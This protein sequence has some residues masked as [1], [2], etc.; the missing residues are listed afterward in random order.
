MTGRIRRLYRRRGSQWTVTALLWATV[1]ASYMMMHPKSPVALEI[2]GYRWTG[3]P[4]VLAVSFAVY[5]VYCAVVSSTLVCARS[6][7]ARYQW[8]GWRL[9]RRWPVKDDRVVVADGAAGTVLKVGRHR[10][11]AAPMAKV[12]LDDGC[13]GWVFVAELGRAS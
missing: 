9:H 3:R 5:G 7:N 6:V 2:I 1:I 10:E 13:S 8:Y 11:S 12:Q 4:V